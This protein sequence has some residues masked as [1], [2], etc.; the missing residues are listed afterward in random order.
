[1][2][3]FDERALGTDQAAMLKVTEELVALHI[4]LH[5]VADLVEDQAYREDVLLLIDAHVFVLHRV[6]TF[7]EM[8]LNFWRHVGFSTCHRREMLL[9]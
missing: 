9:L 4:G 7:D 6:C 1:M 3:A 2:L 8:T 5:F